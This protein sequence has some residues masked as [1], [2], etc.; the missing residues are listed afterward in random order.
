[1]R[2]VG[3]DDRRVL[4]QEFGDGGG[5]R[6]GD[7][8]ARQRLLQAREPGLR[9]GVGG[10]DKDAQVSG[11]VARPV[12]LQARDRTEAA[13]GLRLAVAGNPEVRDALEGG[14]LIEIAG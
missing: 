4:G 3:L 14:P 8:D 6:A 1:V 11:R 13:R 2:K 10:L 12:K 7:V 9:S 5:R